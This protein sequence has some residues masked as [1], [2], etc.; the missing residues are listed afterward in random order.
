LLATVRGDDPPRIHPLWVG[1]VGGRLYAFILKSA[2][3]TDLQRD[4]RYAL[5]THIDPAAPMA[6]TERQAEL[7]RQAAEHPDQAAGLMRQLLE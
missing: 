6:F 4:G 5:H 3:R 7:L 2:K 1:I